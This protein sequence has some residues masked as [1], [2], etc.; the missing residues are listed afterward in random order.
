MVAVVV[1]EVSYKK[2]VGF[3]TEVVIVMRADVVA[4]YKQGIARNLFWN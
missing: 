4:F 1:F 2:N 3:A